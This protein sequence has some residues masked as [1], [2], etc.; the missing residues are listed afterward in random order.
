MRRSNPSNPGTS[1]IPKKKRNRLKAVKPEPTNPQQESDVIL[2]YSG[3]W[4]RDEDP[5]IEIKDGDWNACAYALWLN[6]PSLEIEIRSFFKK[7]ALAVRCVDRSFVI[8]SLIPHYAQVLAKERDVNPILTPELRMRTFFDYANMTIEDRKKRWKNETVKV[9]EHNDEHLWLEE[10]HRTVRFYKL[11]PILQDQW[12]FCNE[13]FLE[14]PHRSFQRAVKYLE[15][16]KEDLDEIESIQQAV[17]LPK[18]LDKYRNRQV[19]K[20][21]ENRIRITINIGWQYNTYFRY[22]IPLYSD[23]PGETVEDIEIPDTLCFDYINNNIVDKNSEPLLAEIIRYAE[24]E[25]NHI[26]CPCEPGVQ[27]CYDN[28]ECPCFRMN[29]ALRKLNNV[30][31]EKTVFCTTEPLYYLGNAP[32]FYEHAAFACSEICG[33]KGVCNNNPMTVITGNVFP[34]EVFRQDT[35]VGFGVRSTSFIPAGVPVMEFCGELIKTGRLEEELKSYSMQ[36]TDP[37]NDQNLMKVINEECK[38]SSSFMNRLNHLYRVTAWHLDCKW[39][40]NISRFLMNSCTPNLEPIRIFQKS[41]SPAH[42]KV[43][44]YSVK[45]IVPGEVLSF[46][47]GPTYDQAGFVCQCGS[48]ACK[49]GPDAAVF[50]KLGPHELAACFTELHQG[51]LDQFEA[52]TEREMLIDDGARLCGDYVF[53][54]RR[55]KFEMTDSFK[56]IDD[57]EYKAQDDFQDYVDFHKMR[58][59]LS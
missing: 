27:S 3:D 55:D 48:F 8:S 19:Y 5:D 54:F 24:E 14:M 40:G 10:K 49:N 59:R 39:Q 31:N 25:E 13:G 43:L 18:E 21:P 12:C 38:F 6:P 26:K 51:A 7:C 15:L 32:D 11:A 4:I 46:D 57:R 47:Y 50:S 20:A 30:E 22:W 56:K 36:L 33:C 35:T 45:S 58:Y 44:M 41:F 42:A 37:K 17:V 34:M 29:I 9:I 2:E 52:I 28:P 23:I 16:T 53:D 1:Q